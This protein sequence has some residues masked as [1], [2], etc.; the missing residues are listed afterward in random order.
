LR[1]SMDRSTAA[2][3]PHAAHESRQIRPHS[4]PHPKGWETATAVAGGRTHGDG[5]R[6][7]EGISVAP[8][9]E[10]QWNVATGGVE[11]NAVTRS[12]TRGMRSRLALAPAGAMV[13]SCDYACG[14]DGCLPPPRRGGH[15]LRTCPT[16]SA[17]LACRRAALHPWLQSIAPPGQ[18]IHQAAVS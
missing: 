4:I 5:K 6:S 14:L 2:E 3:E 7:T 9:P 16:G 11:R 17:P 13:S 1:K 8:A 12:G 10:G 18:H 15:C